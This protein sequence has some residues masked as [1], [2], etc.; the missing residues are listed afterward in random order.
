MNAKVIEENSIEDYKKRNDYSRQPLIIKM[1]IIVTTIFLLLFFISLLV[2]LYYVRTPLLW[3]MVSIIIA[4][5]FYFFQLRKKEIEDIFLFF[6]IE[7]KIKDNK[8]YIKKCLNTNLEYCEKFATISTLITFSIV[9][10]LSGI[11]HYSMPIG[12]L[13]SVVLSF[14]TGIM[15]FH[16]LFKFTFYLLYDVNEEEKYDIYIARNYFLSY[17]IPYQLFKIINIFLKL[18]FFLLIFILVLCSIIFLGLEFVPK[19]QLFCHTNELKTV[20]K[21]IGSNICN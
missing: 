18:I 6:G 19:E 8:L 1:V 14:S 9:S 20:L 7:Y 17:F 16:H 4:I 12:I 5:I 3:S 2:F 15:Y 10:S 13:I 11:R 21:I